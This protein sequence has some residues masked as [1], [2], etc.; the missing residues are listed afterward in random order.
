MQLRKEAE[1]RRRFPLEQ[2]LKQY[3]VGQEGAITT[4]ASGESWSVEW[5]DVA[6]TS[7]ESL[8]T[9]VE[10]LWTPNQSN[11]CSKMAV[12][13]LRL[14]VTELSHWRPGFN[15]RPVCVR[16]MMGEVNLD[17]IYLAILHFSP[18]YH[19]VNAPY[20]FIH[21]SLLLFNLISWQ[22]C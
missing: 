2:R 14:L 3:I 4:V 5:L 11:F 8:I 17:Q 9:G 21:L 13:W 18:V 22:C 1:E 6:G 12:P 20:C 10:W 15:P 16:F 19:A 7:S